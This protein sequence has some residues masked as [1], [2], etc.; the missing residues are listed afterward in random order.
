MHLTHNV[1]HGSMWA[2]NILLRR[3]F[4]T[5]GKSE[6]RLVDWARASEDHYGVP[7]AKLVLGCPTLTKLENAIEKDEAVCSH[8]HRGSA[9]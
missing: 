8:C 4:P 2:R 7:C 6:L 3:D 5:A 9:C 1:S